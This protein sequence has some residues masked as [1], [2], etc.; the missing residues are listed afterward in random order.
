MLSML[1]SSLG[2]KLTSCL[3]GALTMAINNNVACRVILW[4]RRTR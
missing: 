1:A 3:V 2:S 4:Q